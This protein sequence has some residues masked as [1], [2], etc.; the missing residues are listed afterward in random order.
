[1][2]VDIPIGYGHVIQ[3]FKHAAASSQWSIT[4]GVRPDGPGDLDTYA[5]SLGVWFANRWAALFDSSVTIL[6]CQ[7]YYESG[8]GTMLGVDS[9]GPVV[10]GAS[11][12]SSP[13]SV[14]LGITKRTGFVGKHY[15]GRCYLPIGFT[16]TAVDEVGNIAEATVNSYQAAADLWLNDM[17]TAPRTYPGMYLLHSQ[18]SGIVP[19]RVTA[20]QV[21]TIV[22][23][24]RKRLAKPVG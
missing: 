21:R 16:E 13:S 4:Y 8:T 19:T 2:S 12:A 10:G 14:N 17:D 5:T 23:T 3:P 22:R 24:Q 9:G 11:K 7:L 20:L 6:P 1:M 18:G 15:R